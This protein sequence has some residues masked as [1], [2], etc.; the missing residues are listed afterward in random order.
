[1]DGDHIDPGTSVRNPLGLAEA[2][3]S[4]AG[5]LRHWAS[6]HNPDVVVE[7]DVFRIG[8]A[9]GDY[10]GELDHLG[11]FL[12]DA[13]LLIN[14][15][16]EMDI[17][18]QLDRIAVH[19]SLPRL[20]VWSVSGYGGIVALLRP[21]VTG[22]FHC[23][24]LALSRMSEEGRPAVAVPDDD[25][26]VQAP[27]CADQTFTATHP[28]LLPLAIEATRAAFGELSRGEDGH[29]PFDDDVL[30]VQTRAPDGRPIPPSWASFKLPPDPA[31]PMC[32]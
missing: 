13:S 12:A 32:S 11:N 27:G 6:L 3:F 5:A 18:R 28:D 14:A 30:T 17:G 8:L 4:K 16:A 10:Q 25:E 22:C 26:S 29:Q 15:T 23:L 2:G 19:L 7:G 9:A 20:H 1:M 24:E 21:G 31:C